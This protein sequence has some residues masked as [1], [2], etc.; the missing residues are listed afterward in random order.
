[1]A[2]PYDILMGAIGENDERQGV[3][4][5]LDS[6]IP[7]LNYA[8]SGLYRGG[9]GVGR[10]YEI[11]GPASCGKTYLATMLMI[12]AQ[13]MGG[14]AGFSDHERSF[15]DGL[16]NKLGLNTD[17]G[18]HWIYKRPET[19]EESFDTAIEAMTVI[20]EHKLIADDKPIVW[21]F[22]SIASMIP[23]SVLWEKD[24]NT[25][26]LTRRKLTSMT[27][28]DN[29]SLAACMS[30]ALKQMSVFCNDYNVMCLLLNQI[31]LDPGVMFGNPE[32]TPG[33]KACGFYCTGRINLG[34]K[35]L[36]EDK[37]DTKRLTGAV[38]SART[39]KNKLIHE[40][41]QASWRL[42]FEDDGSTTIDKIGTLLD[43]LLRKGLLDKAGAYVVWDGGKVYASVLREKLTKDPT[44]YQQLLDLLP[45]DINPDQGDTDITD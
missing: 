20:R 41:K 38:V 6:G 43:Y 33:G 29:L 4:M 45:A 39:T 35:H 9:F 17:K 22:D 37:A 19:L 44:G 14:I 28:R 10:L 3:G 23:H 25:K 36:K 18:I 15:E 1:M 21:A 11:F 27:M 42:K 30:I 13:K 32:V 12:E 26:K 34:K 40:G 24:K 16:A 8:A 31:R 2:N 7:E 5:Y